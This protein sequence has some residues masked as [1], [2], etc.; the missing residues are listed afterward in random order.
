MTA[1][2]YIFL[3]SVGFIF[4]GVALADLLIFNPNV[5]YN[6]FSHLHFYG[7]VSVIMFAIIVLVLFLSPLFKGRK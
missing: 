2:Q 1:R 3:I 6:W 7:K 5:T 4:F